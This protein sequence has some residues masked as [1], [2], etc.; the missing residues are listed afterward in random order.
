VNLPQRLA[1]ADCQARSGRAC[2][3]AESNSEIFQGVTYGCLQLNPTE[4]G[5]GSIHW[6][7]IDLTAPGIELYVTPLD[8]AAVAHG[9]QYRLRRIKDVVSKENL[10]VAIND[11]MFASDSSASS[12]ETVAADHV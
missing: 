5:N 4:E 1:S 3:R 12:V 11:T 10:A 9:R 2:H 8:A 6:V 7:R